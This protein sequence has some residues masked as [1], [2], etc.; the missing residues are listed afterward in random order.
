MIVNPLTVRIFVERFLFFSLVKVE[1]FEKMKHCIQLE[2]FFQ[3][4]I[5][6]DFILPEENNLKLNIFLYNKILKEEFVNNVCRIEFNIRRI[7]NKFL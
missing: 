5:K 4:L 7:N 2:N 3:N 1:K 6:N